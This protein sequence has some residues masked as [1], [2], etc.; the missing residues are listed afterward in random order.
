[1]GEL[2]NP[3]DGKLGTA[4]SIHRTLR[5][6]VAFRQQFRPSQPRFISDSTVDDCAKTGLIRP[7]NAD[8]PPTLTA[9]DADGFGVGRRRCGAARAGPAGL[10]ANT[11]SENVGL[12]KP[13]REMPRGIASRC[14]DQH[15]PKRR[16]HRRLEGKLGWRHCLRCTGGQPPAWGGLAARETSTGEPP[17]EA[18]DGT[19]GSLRAAGGLFRFIHA[20]SACMRVG[21]SRPTPRRCANSA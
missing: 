21:R 4:R 19:V 10:S 17:H 16:T 5:D 11:S 7:A 8:E 18:G 9:V 6:H 15:C 1:M 3:V 2:A 12:R 20:L 13:H 14:S